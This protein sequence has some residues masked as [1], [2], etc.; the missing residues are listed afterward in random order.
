MA[1]KQIKVGINQRGGPAP[2]YLWSVW[3]LERGYKEIK[4][5]FTEPQYDH[6]VMQVKDLAKEKSPSKSE[7]LSIDKI[8]SFYELRDKGGVLGG[9]NARIFYGISHE[10]KAIIILGGI[11]KQNNG[12]TPL[13]DKVTMR[14]RWRKFE[15]G[16]YGKPEGAK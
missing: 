12:G 9:I 1:K 6:L 5:A 8:E 15:N 3:V 13:G 16:D 11:K 14:R 7:I 10:D 4:A 2:G